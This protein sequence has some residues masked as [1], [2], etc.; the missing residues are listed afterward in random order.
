[1]TKVDNLSN[2]FIIN[3]ELEQELFEEET[4]FQTVVIKLEYF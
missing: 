3:A 2:F 4:V 1:M